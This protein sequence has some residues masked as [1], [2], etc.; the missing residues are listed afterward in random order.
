[1]NNQEEVDIMTPMVWQWSL[2]NSRVFTR[3]AQ[4]AAQAKKKGL[5]VSL[6]PWKNRVFKK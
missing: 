1:L 5:H 3:D 2:G 4:K 6:V